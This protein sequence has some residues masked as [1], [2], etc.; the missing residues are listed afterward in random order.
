VKGREGSGGEGEGK[1]RGRKEGEG[2]GVGKEKGVGSKGT[3]L[4]DSIQCQ[5]GALRMRS[6]NIPPLD[7]LKWPPIC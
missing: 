2:E 4:C 6:S 3:P 7:S 1:G 5:R